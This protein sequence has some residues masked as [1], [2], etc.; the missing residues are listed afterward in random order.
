MA[1]YEFIHKTLFFPEQGILV[2][3]D[4]H[5]G[6]EHAL[7][8]S[9]VLL[10]EQQV[11][12][13]IKNLEMTIEKIKSKKWKL[14]KIVFLGDIKH[15]FS[16]E[17][18]EKANFYKVMDFLK[19]HLAEEDII[20]IRGNHDTMDYTYGDMEDFHIEGNIAFVHGHMPFKEAFAKEIKTVVLGHLH[21]SVILSEN[22][23]VKT[24]TYKCF[25]TGFSRGKEFIIVPSFLEFYEG[26]PVNYY[27]DDYI[28]S[29]SIIPKKD[30]MKFQIHVVGEDGNAYDF[31][32]IMDLN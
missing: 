25:L 5:I 19:E 3:G 20:V 32:R 6:Y 15:F 16:Y 27:D 12:E 7:T 17:Y 29:F 21:P 11:K 26:T 8:Q 10:P 30:M 24:E 23:G 31:G 18:A 2:I 9:G 22:P 4:L 13:T 28:E 1:K 14:K